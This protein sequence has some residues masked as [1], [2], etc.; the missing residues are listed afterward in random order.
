VI[1]SILTGCSIHPIPD[2]VTREST[3]SIVQAIRCETRSAIRQQLANILS[4]SPSAK[5]RQV[6]Q[7]LA[8]GQRDLDRIYLKDIDRASQREMARFYDVGIGYNFEL[9]MEENDNGAANALFKLP[10]TDGTFTLGIGG[11]KEKMRQNRRTFLII[12][13]VKELAESEF[14]LHEAGRRENFIYPISGRIGM[15][16]FVN[17]FYGLITTAGRL[18]QTNKAGALSDQLTFRTRIVGSVNPK[19]ELAPVSNHFKLTEASAQLSADRIDTHQVIVAIRL[20]ERFEQVSQLRGNISDEIENLRRL[21]AFR[22]R[23]F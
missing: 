19:I 12:D 20:P 22:S 4:H 3:L 17:T 13:T 10:F 23:D 16:E 14:C 21:D 8:T 18:D 1:A 11:G 15:D 5:T 2:D 6:S 7:E 9:T